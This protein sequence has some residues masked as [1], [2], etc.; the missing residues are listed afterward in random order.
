[1]QLSIW[2]QGSL[3]AAYVRAL[4]FLAIGQT[5]NAEREFQILSDRARYS[6]SEI[7]ALCHLGLARTAAKAG[8]VEK[9]RSAYEE[10]SAL[11]KD[12]DA[13]IPMLMA[14][15]AEYAHLK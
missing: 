1:M 10:F 9:S 15:R 2:A 4:S 14:A 3:E 6:G 11:W 13:D 12:A 5:A 8:N 7:Y